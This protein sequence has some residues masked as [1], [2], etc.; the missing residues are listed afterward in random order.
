MAMG[1]AVPYGGNGSVYLVSLQHKMPAVL[2]RHVTNTFVSS[3]AISSNGSYMA[4]GGYVSGAKRGH[5][6]I[7]LFDSEGKL[8]WNVSAGSK[9]QDVGVAIAANGSRIAADYG[10]GMFYLNAVGNVLW[11]YTFPETGV[12]THFAMSGDATFIVYADENATVQN[13]AEVGWGIF[14]LSSQGRQLWNYT[15]EHAGVSFV[16]MSSDG[17][18]VAASSILSD[19]GAVYYSNFSNNGTLYYLNG[20]TG[21]LLWEYTYP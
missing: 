8:L 1:A 5:G 16:Q 2:W 12:S 15:Q 21:A 6:E 10:S 4:A 13:R 14:D 18:F 19:N 3:V 17:S 11:N 20:K 9:P 7:F